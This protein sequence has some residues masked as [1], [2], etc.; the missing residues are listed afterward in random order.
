MALQAPK[1]SPAA[2]KELRATLKAKKELMEKLLLENP[3]FKGDAPIVLQGGGRTETDESVIRNPGANDP[4]GTTTKKSV[5]TNAGQSVHANTA[6]QDKVRSTF[7]DLNTFITTAEADLADPARL[8]NRIPIGEEELIDVLGSGVSNAPAMGRVRTFT[9]LLSKM[10]TGRPEQQALI[11]LIQ[12]SNPTGGYTFLRSLMPGARENVDLLAEIM[13]G[14][15]NKNRAAGML[16]LDELQALRTNAPLLA[17]PNQVSNEIRATAGAAG[18]ALPAANKLAN[19]A[20]QVAVS[21][22]A[23]ERNIANMGAD[24]LNQIGKNRRT[25]TIGSVLTGAAAGTTAAMWP[26]NDTTK[27]N[28]KALKALLGT[29]S[30]DKE[31]YKTDPSQALE[32]AFGAYA[33]R[34]FGRSKKKPQY[35]RYESIMQKYAQTLARLGEGTLKITDNDQGLTDLRKDISSFY[36]P[37]AGYE[38]YNA[39]N[40]IAFPYMSGNKPGVISIDKDMKNIARLK[41]GE[42]FAAFDN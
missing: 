29:A 25:A 18:G 36:A 40:P 9:D 26:T 30:I 39:E 34:E 10:E 7:D 42:E 33:E 41:D 4:G 28:Q 20:E 15:N 1:H 5:T 32:N 37:S 17:T 21:A 19:Q 38:G 3:A 2:E 24:A 6:A 8:A 14:M 11:K 12:G 16:N 31:L 13:H 22:P 35:S 23:V 27:F